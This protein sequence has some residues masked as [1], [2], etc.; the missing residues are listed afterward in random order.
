MTPARPPSTSARTI[1]LSAK[2]GV[3]RASTLNVVVHLRRG[4]G[5]DWVEMGVGEGLL[6][7]LLN[8]VVWHQIRHVSRVIL[9]GTD[10]EQADNESRPSTTMDPESR[11]PRRHHPSD[12]TGRRVPPSTSS[13]CRACHTPRRGT[14]CR[15]CDRRSLRWRCCS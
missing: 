6:D 4:L 14:R 2:L 5:C 15:Y 7:S 1:L 9:A 11:G 8:P 10:N 3:C 13:E 12:C